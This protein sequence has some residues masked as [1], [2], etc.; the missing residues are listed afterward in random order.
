[1]VSALSLIA[2]GLG[3]A[4]RVEP[5][6]CRA[7]ALQELIVRRT[8]HRFSLIKPDGTVVDTVAGRTLV[9]HR[10]RVTQ[11]D[12]CTITHETLHSLHI[13]PSLVNAGKGR[14]FDIGLQAWV[15]TKTKRGHCCVARVPK[16]V[17]SAHDL[18]IDTL[19]LFCVL[20]MR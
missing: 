17:T 9:T 7:V 12:C 2:N 10:V 14:N 13:M 16:V 11:V 1:M 18:H 3:T 4:E 19:A 15:G 5:Y 20:S 8:V 6:V